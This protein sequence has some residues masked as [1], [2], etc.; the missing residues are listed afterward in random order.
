MKTNTQEL[1]DHINNIIDIWFDFNIKNITEE[2]IEALK[3]T[4]NLTL[5]DYC[6]GNH[7]N[8]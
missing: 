6:R 3:E 1:N 2:S 7:D 8:Y 4:I 5:K